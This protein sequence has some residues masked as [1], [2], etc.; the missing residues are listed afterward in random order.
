MLIKLFVNRADFLPSSLPTEC[1][2]NWLL[3]FGTL[4]ST[5]Y[6]NVSVSSNG[7]WYNKYG[8]KSGI[9]RGGWI[10]S[11]QPTFNGR[12]DFFWDNTISL[13]VTSW[14]HQHQHYLQ[15]KLIF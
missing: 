11:N 7:Q 14:K 10:E 6:S 5:N 2:P 8:A 3:G 4:S 15:I 1:K 9:S 13:V 12:V